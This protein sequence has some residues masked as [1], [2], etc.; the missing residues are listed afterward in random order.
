MGIHIDPPP[1]A[2]RRG[3]VIGELPFWHAWHRGRTSQI[4]YAANTHHNELIS[5]TDAKGA[6]LWK[7]IA[8]EWICSFDAGTDHTDVIRLGVGTYHI[9]D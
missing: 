2:V 9:Q 1:L 5:V 6:P 4:Y 3:S 8:A 7:C